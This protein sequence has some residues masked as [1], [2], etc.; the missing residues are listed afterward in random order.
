LTDLIAFRTD[1]RTFIFNVGELNPASA[2]A[3]GLEE[4][5]L[6]ETIRDSKF[7][8]GVTLTL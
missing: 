8:V 6:D 2:T 4:A 7:T 5:R 3:L 1:I